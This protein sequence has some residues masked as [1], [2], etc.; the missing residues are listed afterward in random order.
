MRY[1]LPW[2]KHSD[3]DG[4]PNSFSIPNQNWR[5]YA[6]SLQDTYDKLDLLMSQIPD[7]HDTIGS[8]IG[9]IREGLGGVQH[10]NPSGK[11]ANVQQHGITFSTASLWLRTGNRSKSEMFEPFQWGVFVAS[12]DAS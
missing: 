5:M 2:G 11:W 1:L 3:R 4:K 8:L 9:E 7:P 6:Y 10:G 12:C